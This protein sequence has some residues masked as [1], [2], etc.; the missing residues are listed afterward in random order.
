MKTLKFAPHLVEKIL[1]GEKTAT[2]R[3]FDDKDLKE[4]DELI[5][6]N[7]ETGE[8]FGTATITSLKVT[9]LGTLTDEDR[10]GHEKYTSDDEIYASFR[11][12]YG[13]KVDENSEVKILTFDF[14]DK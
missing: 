10:A 12:Y 14:K 4:G 7:K 8:Q 11:K 1:S 3:L 5:F 13:D 6:I 2:W 9:T